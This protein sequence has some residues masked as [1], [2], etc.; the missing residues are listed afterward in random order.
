VTLKKPGRIGSSG[1]VALGV[2]LFMVFLNST[3]QFLFFLLS[4]GEKK[5]ACLRYRSSLCCL[6]TLFNLFLCAGCCLMD[7]LAAGI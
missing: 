3:V 7:M 2:V 5:I 6:N 1:G 4:G